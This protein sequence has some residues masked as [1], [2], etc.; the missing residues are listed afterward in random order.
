MT[1][2]V[3]APPHVLLLFSMRSTGR[4]LYSDMRCTRQLPG[5]IVREATS[6]EKG[7][8]EMCLRR[9][10]LERREIGMPTGDSPCEAFDVLVLTEVG[11]KLL[12]AYQPVK[13]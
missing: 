6:A 5:L 1:P 3:S 8:Y 4:S 10:L 2:I 9:G 13:R 7:A 11:L 12:D